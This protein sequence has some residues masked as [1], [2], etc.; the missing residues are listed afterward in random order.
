MTTLLHGSLNEE[1][2]YLRLGLFYKGSDKWMIQSGVNIFKG[3]SET[4]QIGM[5]EDLSNFYMAIRINF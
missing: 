5:L 3:K 1:D 2:A 4:T